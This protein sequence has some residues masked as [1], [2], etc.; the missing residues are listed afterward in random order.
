VILEDNKLWHQEVV[1]KVVSL[2]TEVAKWRATAQ[3]LWRVDCPKVVSA[4]VAFAEAVRMNRQLSFKVGDALAKLL[5][6]R[7]DGDDLFRCC[8][9]LKIKKLDL[10]GKVESVAVEKDGLAKRIVELEARLMESKSKLVE[11]EL[12][13]A[14]ERGANKELEEKLLLYKK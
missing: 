5:C 8:K 2:E 7:L 12:Q 11:S 3:T 1:Q 9:G 10:G 6:T 14:K 4:I 13:V